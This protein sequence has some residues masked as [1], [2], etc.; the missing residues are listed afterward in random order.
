[1]KM[2]GYIYFLLGFI[3]AASF[4][5][6]VWYIS[7]PLSFGTL[8]LGWYLDS[9]DRRYLKAL[10]EELDKSRQDYRDLLTEYCERF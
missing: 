8:G 9:I 3:S 1:M 7:I 6:A 10:S 2:P 4:F 5:G